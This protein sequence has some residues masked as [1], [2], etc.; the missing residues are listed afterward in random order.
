MLDVFSALWTPPSVVLGCPPNRGNIKWPLRPPCKC[1]KGST[2]CNY[3]NDDDQVKGQ[4][5][6]GERPEDVL[7]AP[8][9]AHYVAFQ[10][11]PSV[12]TCVPVRPCWRWSTRSSR[13]DRLKLRHPISLEFRI[14]Y[15]N[16]ACPCAKMPA[17]E[18]WR[19]LCKLRGSSLYRRLPPGGRARVVSGV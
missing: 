8:R 13:H 12:L 2:S 17:P 14:G 1:A 5:V 10:L 16:A 9:V 19:K 3:R 15:S 7:L 11:L 6:D 18:C 4:A